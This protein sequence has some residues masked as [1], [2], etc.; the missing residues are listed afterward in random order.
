MIVNFLGVGFDLTQTFYPIK[1]IMRAG[2]F[3]ETDTRQQTA[4]P[5]IWGAWKD[6]L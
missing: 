6:C 3:V 4:E 5:G 1:G 2:S